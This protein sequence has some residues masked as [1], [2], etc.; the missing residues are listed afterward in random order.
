MLWN[1]RKTCKMFNMGFSVINWASY[2]DELKPS[3]ASWSNFIYLAFFF[4]LTVRV[5]TF[6]NSSKTK[7]LKKFKFIWYINTW[8]QRKYK[9]SICNWDFLVTKAYSELHQCLSKMWCLRQSCT[10]SE[11]CWRSKCEFCSKRERTCESCVYIK[12]G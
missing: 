8:R 6:L 7:T 1:L 3:E 11:I 5:R 9:V 12:Y 4:L 2:V 10:R